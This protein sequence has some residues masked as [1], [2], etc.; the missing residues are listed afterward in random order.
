MPIEATWHEPNAILLVRYLGDIS[1]EELE[2]GLEEAVRL[3]LEPASQP[4]HIIADQREVKRYPNLRLENIKNLK[5]FMNHPKLGWTVFIG[6]NPLLS[7]WLKIFIKIFSFKSQ[8][9]T[10][11]KDA[12]TFL[13]EIIR[14][15]KPAQKI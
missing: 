6:T 11:L 12:D 10:S 13:Q 7:F 15:S 8:T 2:K 9:L 14:L 4:I 5:A 1:A 3:Y